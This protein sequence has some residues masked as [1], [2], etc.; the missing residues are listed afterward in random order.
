MQRARINLLRRSRAATASRRWHFG[1]TVVFL[2][3]TGG[4]MR[5]PPMAQ[6]GG[7][8]AAGAGDQGAPALPGAEFLP[9]PPS[10]GFR[11]TSSLAP[12]NAVHPAT[13][14]LATGA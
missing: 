10:G 6:E 12:P 1:L 8:P 9:P 5:M 3:L 7:A 2:L 14:P 11:P 13:P 4:L